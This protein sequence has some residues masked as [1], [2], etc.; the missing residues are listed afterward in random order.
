[1]KKVIQLAFIISLS[2]VTANVNAQLNGL[3]KKA[4]NK[5]AEKMPATNGIIEEPD[6]VSSNTQTSTNNN[7]NEYEY[8]L[9]GRWDGTLNINQ[10]KNSG[11]LFDPLKI[12]R[13]KNEKGT[14]HFA[15]DYAELVPYTKVYN[16]NVRIS[17]SSEPFTTG[18]KLNNSFSSRNYI[19]ARLENTAGSIKD[20]FKLGDGDDKLIVKIIV[21][22]D[23]EDIVKEFETNI[24][25]LY[26]KADEAKGKF[27]D[28]DIKPEPGKIT[29]HSINDESFYYSPFFSIQSQQYFPVNGQYRIGVQVFSRVKDDWGK[30][31]WYNIKQCGAHFDYNFS[32]ADV[33]T[34]NKEAAAISDNMKDAVRYAL[35]PLPKQWTEKSSPLVMGFTQA[36]LIAMYEKSFS[37]K[38]D[39]HTTVKFHAS[40]SAGGWTVVNNDYGIPKYRYSN[41]WHTIFIKYANGKTCFYQGFGLRQ[42]YNGGG[43]YGPAFIDKNDYYMTDCEL[44][45]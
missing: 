32:A 13:E 14:F 12:M 37:N 43:T 16:S 35:K 4:K 19:Y 45:K 26:L 38:M 28:F 33:S 30:E 5:S 11:S 8:F 3:L 2:L 23:K 25:F 27:I 22:N 34:I 39:A 6:Q 1:M 9:N 31:D 44:M 24:W 15:K 36:Q 18:E 41:Q 29:T 17:F 21:F 20:A 10:I 7:G 40:P 42:Q